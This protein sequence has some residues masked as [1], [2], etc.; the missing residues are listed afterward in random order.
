MD[1]I[2]VKWTVPILVLTIGFGA[3]PG[4]AET[5]VADFEDLSL[6]ANSSW[7][8][9]DTDGVPG[10]GTDSTFFSAGLGFNN[11]R[12]EEWDYWDGWAYSNTADMTTPGYL[13]YSAYVSPDPGPGKAGFGGSSNYAVA[14]NSFRGLATVEIPA[15]QE[16][17]GAWITNT[18]YAYL[19]IK[20]GN[21]GVPPDFGGPLVRQFTTG[22]WFKLEIFGVDEAGQDVGS[23]PFFL[24]SYSGYI[25]G[26]SDPDN[27]IVTDWTYVD[28]SSLRGARSL[29]FAL[30]STD[31]DPNPD[32]GMNTPAYFAIDNVT[33]TPE[34]SAVVMIVS[35]ALCAGLWR[36]R[37]RGI[38]K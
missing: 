25:E 17:D 35:A 11:Y 26:I 13:N 10:T 5:V 29:E 6:D 22:D 20:D 8:G 38:G 23:V 12:D 34:P 37:R 3:A 15:G 4:A 30:S 36:R 1:S 19:A 7:N 24:A 27:F 33:T 9:V 16:I 2:N 31:N 32:I 28:L 18:T 21:D 14:Y